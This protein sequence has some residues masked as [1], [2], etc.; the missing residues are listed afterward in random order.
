LKQSD[1]VNLKD[2]EKHEFLEFLKEE[3]EKEIEKEKKYKL[4]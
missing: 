2:N 3:N 4:L 1:L